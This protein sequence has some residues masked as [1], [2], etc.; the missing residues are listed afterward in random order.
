MERD[1]I[2][3]R[4]PK[5]LNEELKEQAKSKGISRH[6]LILQLLWNW[7]EKSA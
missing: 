2:V 3:L 5:K 4:I 6:A 1:E 7:N